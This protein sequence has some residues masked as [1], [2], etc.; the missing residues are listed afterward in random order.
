[1]RQPSLWLAIGEIEAT[2]VCNSHLPRLRPR[3]V[4]TLCIAPFGEQSVVPIDL[5]HTDFGEVWAVPVLFTPIPRLVNGKDLD[6]TYSNVTPYFWGCI[7]TVTKLSYRLH[8]TLQTI[9]SGSPRSSS[10]S[11]LLLWQCLSLSPSYSSSGAGKALSLA[12]SGGHL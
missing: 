8:A 4:L 9:R 2:K 10:P 6:A 1:M 3:H 12:R 5:P 11:F 7:H